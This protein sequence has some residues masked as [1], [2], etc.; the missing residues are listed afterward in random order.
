MS[1]LFAPIELRGLKLANR[2]MVSPMCQYSAEAG[3]ATDWHFTHI[4]NLALSGAAMFCIEATHVEDI[5]RITP[6]C[7]GLYSDANEA[8]LKPILAS[9]RKHSKSAIAMQL[10]HAGRKGSSARPWDGGQLIPQDKGGWQPVAPSAVAHKD[11]ETAPTA[12][13][14]AGLSRIRDAFVASTKRA[15]RLGIDAIELHGAHGYLLHQ[16]LSPIANKRTDKYGGSLENRMR[17]PLEVFDAVRAAFPDNKPVGVRVSATDWVEGGWDLAQ[18]IEFAKEL[19][20]RRVD[21]IDVSSGGVSPLQKIPL[22]PGYQVPLA[23]GV[24]EA[25]GVTTMAVGLITEPKQAEE[26][27]ASGKADMVTLARGMLYDPRWGWHAAA[28][29]HGEVTAPPQYWRSQPSSQKALFGATSFGA[30]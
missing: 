13:D 27:V 23:Q 6:G 24:K 12:L 29:L 11:S 4:N 19:K 16:F 25:T 14:D 8:A 22:G 26:I 17:Y 18:T 3:S 30:R 5:G 7:L 15:A 1:S 20:K 2:I 21:W 28:E 10:A 9:V